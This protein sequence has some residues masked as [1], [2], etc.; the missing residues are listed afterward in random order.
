M[1]IDSLNRENMA[2]K[3]DN[4]KLRNQNQQAQ[5]HITDLSTEKEQL[6]EKVAIAS[7][8]NATGIY[9]EA[10]NKRGKD[11]K[12]ISKAKKFVISFNLARNVTTETGMRFVY[13]RIA[14]PTGA[15]LT[16]GGTFQYENR[17]L[18]YSIAKEVEYTGEELPVTVYWDIAETLSAGGYR[19][20]I[21]CD[22]QNIG[23]TTFDMK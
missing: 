15:V 13:V 2:L 14:T 3:V 16:N 11:T 22:G 17:E 4:D 7:Q 12:K 5:A 8:L 10:Q 19:V 21:F 1:Q 9:V 6:V 18:Q 23:S 20:D